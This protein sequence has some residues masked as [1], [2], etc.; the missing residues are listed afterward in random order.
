[1]AKLSGFNPAQTSKLQADIE[2]AKKLAMKCNN[3][4]IMHQDGS[5]AREIGLLLEDT[6]G[7]SGADRGQVSQIADRFFSFR[8]RMDTVKMTFTTQNSSNQN[9][10]GH[11]AFVN[12][13]LG[14]LGGHGNEILVTAS[15]FQNGD[16]ERAGTLIHEHIH[17][18]N[19]VP[20]HP[21][22]NTALKFFQRTKIGIDFRDAFF[23]PYCY[24][25]FAEWLP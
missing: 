2:R 20:G 10:M 19:G 11:S 17:L 6:F 18:V 16:L 8:G 7:I 1:M 24:Q 15:Y 12:F 9:T 22:H 21:P 5:L 14:G 23:N 4:L 25:Y 13:K 3:R